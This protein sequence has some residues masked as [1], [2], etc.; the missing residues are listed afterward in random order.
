MFFTYGCLWFLLGAK[1]RDY[2]VFQPCTFKKT[3]E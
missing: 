3:V 1:A 2:C